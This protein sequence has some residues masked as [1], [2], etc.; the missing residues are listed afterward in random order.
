VLERVPGA[1][2]WVVGEGDYKE[3]LV[4]IARRAGVADH[5]RFPGFMGGKDK[6]RLLQESRVLTYTSPKEGWGLSVIEAG[7]TATPVLASD[8]PGLCESVVDGKTGFLVRHGDL[9]DLGEKLV[10]LLADDARAQRMAEEG[11]RWAAN[12]R[13]EASAERTLE[14]IEEILGSS[15]TGTEDGATV[16]SE[17]T[18]R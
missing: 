15:R 10:T 16:A 9:A 7:A 4:R 17:E 12:F 8:S 11:V 6:V 5:V 14:L 2:Y 1:E 13:W 3:A 18:A